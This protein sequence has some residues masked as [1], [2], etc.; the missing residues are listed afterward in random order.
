MLEKIV[1]ILFAVVTLFATCTRD[2][3]SDG[4][5]TLF[6]IDL[7]LLGVWCLLTFF[8]FRSD[9]RLASPV[10]YVLML[11]T[12]IMMFF[13]INYAATWGLVAFFADVVATA[14]LITAVY[15][16]IRNGSFRPR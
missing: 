14:F 2:L 7:C 4:Q 1:S 11:A 5:V 9:W 13:Q 12:L 10:G 16:Y 8:E 15:Y 6:V 3:T